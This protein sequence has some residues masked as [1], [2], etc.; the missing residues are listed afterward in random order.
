MH[1]TKKA[2]LC[3]LLT[4]A[5]IRAFHPFAVTALIELMLLQNITINVYLLSSSV[6]TITGALTFPPP[7]EV[8]AN[9]VML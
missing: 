6:M 5:V 8:E 1:I 7:F 4:F 2:H 3:L 9:T